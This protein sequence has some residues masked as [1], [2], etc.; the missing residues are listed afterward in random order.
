M[1]GGFAWQNTQYSETNVSAKTQNLVTGLI[2]GD[3]RLFKFNK[4]N[5]DFTGTLF[6]ALN[7]PGRVKFN[8]NSTYYIKITGNL[9]WNLSFYGNWDNQPPP[10]FC[11]Q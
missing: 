2:A 1:L 4:T 11:W 6:P 8:M 10:G 9:S 5:L 7:Q 3:V